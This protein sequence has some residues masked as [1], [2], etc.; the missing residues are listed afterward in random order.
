MKKKS[1]LV[2]IS[3]LG[4]IGY[5]I[6]PGTCATVVTLPFM[7]FLRYIAPND[8]FYF[9]CIACITV[10]FYQVIAR[11]LAFFAPRQ[12]PCEIVL[13]ECIGCLITFVAIPLTWYYIALGFILFRF[14]D[15]TKI[16][17][18]HRC[19]RLAGAVGVIADDVLAAVWSNLILQCSIFIISAWM[20]S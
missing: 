2:S 5:L 7:F 4:F 18:I 16:L 9:F 10:L 11:A 12:D 14:F 17:G 20:S 3:T 19:E 15:I 1:L 13:D 6:A 8:Y